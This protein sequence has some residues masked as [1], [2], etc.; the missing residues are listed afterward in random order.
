MHVVNSF[1][2]ETG[3][4]LDV[5]AYDEPPFARTGALD[6]ELFLNKTSRDSNSARAVVRR[7]HMHV[8][9]PLAG[10]ALETASNTVCVC[11]YLSLSDCVPL[12][13]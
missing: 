5:G 6:I 11:A 13:L 4:T 9:G 8:S 10:W 7:V 12:S 2:N 3:V 1:E